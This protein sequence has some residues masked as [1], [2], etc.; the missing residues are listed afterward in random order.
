MLY[1]VRLLSKNKC[2]TTSPDPQFL[3]ML[4]YLHSG[5]D[6]KVI[7]VATRALT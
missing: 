6:P 3:G 5:I 1:E 7:F 4:Y 2:I